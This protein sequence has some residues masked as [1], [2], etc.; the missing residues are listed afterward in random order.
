MDLNLALTWKCST[1][2]SL[3]IIKPVAGTVGRQEFESNML[4]LCFLCKTVLRTG[5]EDAAVKRDVVNVY[6]AAD[7]S[8][9][10]HA[11]DRVAAAQGI[12]LS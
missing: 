9:L 12:V 1:R 3:V 10:E 6:C 2:H 7:M 4:T 5:E 8:R 11:A